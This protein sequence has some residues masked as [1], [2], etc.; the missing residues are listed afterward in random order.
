LREIV[1][2][3]NEA[4]I[5][6]NAVDNIQTYIRGKA[7][8]SAALNPLSTIFRVPY[9]E[10]AQPQAFA[11]N[12]ALMPEAFAVADAE[13]VTLFW[14]RAEEY[15]EYLRRKQIPDTENPHSP[16]LND[17]ERGRKT[18]IDFVNGIFVEL[19]K[20]HQIPTPVNETIVRLIKFLEAR[21]GRD[22]RL[23]R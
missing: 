15:L 16:L 22:K 14:E 20:K 17:I 10:L 12:E 1:T 9:G 6:S 3:F 4:G 7:V 11:I 8:Y 21:Y 2:I 19:G 18:E 13:N 23:N 5:P